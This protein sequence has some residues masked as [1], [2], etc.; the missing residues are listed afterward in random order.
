MVSIISLIFG[1]GS[2]VGFILEKNKRKIEQKSL[3][4][5]ALIS[6]Q[7][8]YDNF[9]EDANQRYQLL[10]LDLESIR[11]ELENEKIRNKEMSIKLEECLD[12]Q[13]RYQ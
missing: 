3:A 6:M 11:A 7:R 13:K 2:L 12:G 5:D 9:T 4:T 10:K 1:S 8:A